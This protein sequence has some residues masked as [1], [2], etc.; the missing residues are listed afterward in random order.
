M[1]SESRW[2]L[3]R[4]ASDRDDWSAA[5][6]LNFTPRLHFAEWHRLVPERKQLPNEASIEY[7]VEKHKL[8]RVSCHLNDEQHV[9]FLIDGLANRQ[10]P[11]S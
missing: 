5:F 11:E 6:I 9:S 4:P 10:P 8:L 3:L 1:R 2:R 7:A